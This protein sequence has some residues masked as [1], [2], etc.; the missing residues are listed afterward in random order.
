MEA[1][2]KHVSS[3]L[4]K[5]YCEQYQINLEDAQP[6]KYLQFLRS[7]HP[8]PMESLVASP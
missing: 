5:I 6:R 4:D 7:Q 8:I 1:V 3:P 2:V